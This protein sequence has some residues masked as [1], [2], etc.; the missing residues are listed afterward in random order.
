MEAARV[1]DITEVDQK[2]EKKALQVIDIRSGIAVVDND[3][4]RWRRR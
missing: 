2:I 4:L 3:T 1:I